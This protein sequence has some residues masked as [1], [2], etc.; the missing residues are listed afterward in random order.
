MYR[1]TRTAA[2]GIFGMQEVSRNIL[3]T[4]WPPSLKDPN[5]ANVTLLAHCDDAEDFVSAGTISDQHWRNNAST[6]VKITANSIQVPSVIGPTITSGVVV[7]QFGSK[8]TAI[9]SSS[10][11]LMTDPTTPVLP[12]GTGDFTI[13]GWFYFAN[14][15]GVNFL[16]CRPTSGT[17]G[18]YPLIYLLGTG[19]V[20]YFVNSADRITGA[21]GAVVVNTWYHIA[22]SRVSGNTYLYVNGAQQGSTFVDATNY[23]ATRIFIGSSSNTGSMGGYIQEIRV[24][25]GVGRY[26][27]ATCT[28]PTAKFPDA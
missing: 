16:D 17:N 5:F 22:V 8:C 23:V 21:A 3:D 25:S 12:G 13:E 24:T 2:V 7:P 28:V 11:G 1:P 14:V 18:N 9:V 4:T 15:T 10:V 26:S 19:S 6:A 20:R 27:G